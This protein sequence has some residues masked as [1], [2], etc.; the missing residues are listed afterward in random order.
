MSHTRKQK[1]STLVLINTRKSDTSLLTL[2]LQITFT[3]LEKTIHLK[4]CFN[5]FLYIS[6]SSNCCLVNECYLRNNQIIFSVT[7]RYEVNRYGILIP[8][9]WSV[10]EEKCNS[11]STGGLKNECRMPHHNETANSI[12]TIL[13]CTFLSD[14]TLKLSSL[15]NQCF[16]FIYL[17]QKC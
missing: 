10:C 16:F 13:C 11:S 6:T 4:S 12:I 5:R 7:I 3:L 15:S 1:V 14:V 2:E 8:I 9:R 17:V